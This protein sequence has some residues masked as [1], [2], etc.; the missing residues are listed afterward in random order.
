M[1]K[2]YQLA[3]GTIVWLGLTDKGNAMNGVVASKVAKAIKEIV[4]THQSSTRVE[5]P[6]EDFI[7][8]TELCSAAD[9]L[10]QHP[11]GIIRLLNS[12]AYW[13]RLWIIQEIIL[14]QHLV[15]QCGPHTIDWT[16][17]DR[18]FDLWVPLDQKLT[19][20]S[21]GYSAT[22]Y[23]KELVDKTQ[24]ELSNSTPKKVSTSDSGLQQL[25]YLVQRKRRHV[26]IEGNGLTWK[27]AFQLSQGSICSHTHDK[28]FGL[29]GIVR[30]SL[31]FQADYDKS[32]YKLFN[33]VMGL[34]IEEEPDARSAMTQRFG[35]PIL[36]YNREASLLSDSLKLGLRWSEVGK[37]VEDF[38]LR[39]GRWEYLASFIPELFGEPHSSPWDHE[40]AYNADLTNALGIAPIAYTDHVCKAPEPVDPELA[41]AIGAEMVKVARENWWRGIYPFG[42]TFASTRT[43]IIFSCGRAQPTRGPRNATSS[44]GRLAFVDSTG[45]QRRK[46]GCKVRVEKELTV[47]VKTIAKYDFRWERQDNGYL[48]RNLWIDDEDYLMSVRILVYWNAMFSVI[49]LLCYSV[50]L[51]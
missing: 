33:I 46:Q 22:S 34:E 31:R 2:I 15:L 43:A 9:V 18:C 35:P 13:R 23:S 44:S 19:T 17:F 5:I 36:T 51:L 40:R 27:E 49:L 48:V 41:A 32:L 14:S 30:S 24:V 50:M 45:F 38:Y 28:I 25:G 1:S 7:L 39:T 20:A 11:L 3:T 21:F 37:I 8:P 26:S 4:C 6:C 29:L 10:C 42:Q 16:G 12:A 47:T